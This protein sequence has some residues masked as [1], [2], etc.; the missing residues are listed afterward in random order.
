M[1][2]VIFAIV[3]WPRLIS[4]F[5]LLLKGRDL[6]IFADTSLAQGKRGTIFVEAL[7]I[8]VFPEHV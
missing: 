8:S 6:M 1:K 2:R 3:I 7:F 5:H 4:I